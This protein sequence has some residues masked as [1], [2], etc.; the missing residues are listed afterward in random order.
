MAAPD[1]SRTSGRG[2]NSSAKHRLKKKAEEERKARQ[3][4]Q[5]RLQIARARRA[6]T[7]R[8]GPNRSGKPVKTERQGPVNLSDPSYKRGNRPSEFRLQQEKRRRAGKSFNPNDKSR[9]P[10]V[11]P[12]TNRLSRAARAQQRAEQIATAGKAAK[13][14]QQKSAASKPAAQSRAYTL[15]ARNREYDRLRKAG[16]L[17][18]AEALGRRIAADARKKRR[19]KTPVQKRPGLA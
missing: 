18:E 15:D 4:R 3:R 7:G 10:S 5:E 13:R 9:K 17:K 8:G 2:V 12:G 16:K 14:R 6:R 1:R 19:K 11:E